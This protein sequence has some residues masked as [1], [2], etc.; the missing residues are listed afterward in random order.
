[1]SLLALI[2]AG[3][4]CA[5]ERRKEPMINGFLFKQVYP[6]C[7]VEHD[8][9]VQ[10]DDDDALPEIPKVTLNGQRLP[11]TGWNPIQALYQDLSPFKTDTTYDLKI[12]HYWG[13]ATSRVTMP[14]DSRMTWPESSYVLNRDSLLEIKWLKSRGAT[15]YWLN[16]FINYDY[17]D[18]LG[19][20]DSYEFDRDTILYDTVCVY[21]RNRFF[22]WYV[23]EILEG[24]AEAVV[25]ACDGPVPEPGAT[26]N[27]MGHGFGFINSANQPR[28]AWFVVV[29]PPVSRLD[30]TEPS[31]HRREVLRRRLQ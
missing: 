4:T 30:R 8:R 9:W 19:E 18:T 15:W 25:W 11:M 14:A 26:G 13:E 6:T 27:V 1:M 31:R 3:L 20:W 17:N 16:L 29:Q 2:L 23:R 24:E 12:E 21:E 5:R 28:E 10:I 7:I 22:P